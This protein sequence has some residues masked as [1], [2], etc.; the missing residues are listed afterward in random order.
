MSDTTQILVVDD[1][2]L[3]YYKS[4][5][6]DIIKKA[7]DVERSHDRYDTV[8]IKDDKLLP[9]KRFGAALKSIKISAE[10]PWSTSIFRRNIFEFVPRISVD[11]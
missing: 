1:G 11:K 9:E 3:K 4:N 2:V 8:F 5:N 7:L 10:I 6:P